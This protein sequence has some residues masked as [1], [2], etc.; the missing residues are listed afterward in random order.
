MEILEILESKGIEYEHK[1]GDEYAVTCPHEH[2]HSDG[3]DAR[4][5]F[6]LNVAKRVAHCFS[7]GHS[8]SE[9]GL[10]RWLLG[11][12]LDE[13]QA[14]G[15]QLRGI[16]SRLS[17]TE[18]VPVVEKE[19]EV[20][21]PS[22]EPWNEDGYR[23]ISLETYRR[24]GAIRCQRGRY[25]GR[26][27]FPVYLN[28]E[29]IGVDARALGDEQPKWLRN[30]GQLVK[31]RWLG[32]HDLIKAMKPDLILM[33]E[34]HF[35]CINGLD[36]GYAATCVF[37]IHNW[38]ASKIMLLLSLG[39]TEVCFFP[40]CDKAGFQ[41]AQKICASLVPW[42][43]VTCADASVYHGTG[44]DMGDLTQEEM[45]AAVAGRGKIQLPFCL[46]ENWEFKIEF[47]AECK[48]WKCPFN[49]R[50]NCGNELYEPEIREVKC[51]TS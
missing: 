29:L 4:K 33:G 42:F 20:F 27:V 32:G 18:E 43:K 40:D 5:S 44:K 12:D 41:A 15:L 13:T 1:G 24:V 38:S 34:G 46:L 49:R 30:R 51:S 37:G 39:A 36:K 16:L 8:M 23:G 28:G 50:G 31:S 11:E 10:H 17:K 2:L 9:A 22:G 25:A 35:H 45:D 48:K 14:L 47:A 21:F 19:H 6:N 3:V 7:C 26:I